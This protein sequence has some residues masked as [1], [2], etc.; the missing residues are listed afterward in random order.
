L[1]LYIATDFVG[2][3]I[4]TTKRI[5]IGGGNKKSR[6]ICGKEHRTKQIPPM[7][8]GNNHS[9]LGNAMGE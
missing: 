4:S 8:L 7:V 1:A 6:A 2:Y 9:I 5:S 3:E